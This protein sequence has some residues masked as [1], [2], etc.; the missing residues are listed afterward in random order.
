M[1]KHE[2]IEQ[3]RKTLGFKSR[4]KFAEEIGI[5]FPTLRAY[6]QGKIENIP[7]SFFNT[8]VS[9]F[10]INLNWLM[11]G[12][13]DMFVDNQS[14]IQ[15]N[16]IKH[17]H[18]KKSPGASVIDNSIHKSINPKNEPSNNLIPQ[19]ILSDISNLFTLANA[20]NKVDDL[21]KEL[22]DFVYQQKKLL[23]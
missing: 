2:R 15:I 8:L 23:R 14:D 3:I 12:D 18:F 5:P 21:I 19:D 9:K 1:F 10:N 4:E 6:E 16:D 13:G 7:H 22:D 20:K 11:S 17:T